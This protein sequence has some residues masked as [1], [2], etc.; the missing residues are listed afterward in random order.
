MINA[1]SKR[2]SRALL[3]C[4]VL[5]WLSGCGVTPTPPIATTSG[6]VVGEQNGEFRIFR[7]IPYAAPPVGNLRW[8]PPSPPQ[9]WDAPRAAQVHGP[10]CWQPGADDP[11]G[12]GNSLFLARMAEGSGMSAFNRWLLTTLAGFIDEERSEDCLTLNII[13][14]SS[15][16]APLPV[17]FWIHG[18]GHQFG[19][20]GGPYASTS[21]AG[22]G[23][24]L[25]SI[26]YRLG[27]Y[28]FF[29]HPQLA[30]EDPNG[31]T[32]N[33]GMLDQIAALTWVR[34]NIAN[35]GGDPNNVTIFGE[36]AGGHSVGQLMA[37]PLARNLFH[38]A[39]AQ[40]G[41]G[42]YQFQAI[43]TANEQMSGFE[44]GR[45]L[46]QR[47][48]VSGPDVLA[49]LRAMSTDELA[50]FAL[51][52]ELSETY[53]PQIDGH[54]LPV[55]TADAFAQGKQAPVPLIVGSNAD[56][57]TV[58]YDLGLTPIDGADVAQPQ[59]VAAWHTLLEE[60][61]G[62][63]ADALDAAYAVDDDSDVH[64]AATALM[65]DTWFGRHAYF[66]AVEHSR[67]GHPTF[68]YMYERNPPAEN[69]TIGASHAL[70]LA[71]VFGG[72]LPFWPWDA[73]DDELVV[74]MQSYW[75]R[76]ARTGDPNGD[77]HPA[78][79]PFA[80]ATQEEMA[81]T[82]GGSA[83]RRIARLD[84]YRAMTPQFERRLRQVSGR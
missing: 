28:G 72:F 38:R 45:L 78:W 23:V 8:R 55:S 7:G 39:I 10:V 13:A 33:Y 36:S 68:L 64:A 67:A 74:Q 46:A 29:A 42:F 69:Q 14:P 32:G 50:P 15:A 76:F 48:G 31:S 58:L 61:F 44:A 43:A 22:N 47:A 37:S 82:D 12:N 2:A 1:A 80:A 20:G 63:N 73:R 70:E 60:H 52:P 56:E 59:T 26:N 6:P 84:R 16:S 83:S 65:G 34:D 62:A 41:T 4:I 40:S 35:F 11:G 49:R 19:S 75:S 71:H 5:G 77:G 53:H 66:M 21:L 24:V 81:F 54:V 3:A 9:P 17:M 30:V 18:G 51:D 27:L 25:V 79:A 57:G